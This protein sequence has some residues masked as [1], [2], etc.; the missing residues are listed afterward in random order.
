MNIVQNQDISFEGIYY[1][2]LCQDGVWRYITIDDHLPVRYDGK[3]HLLF[4]HIVSESEEYEVW[5]GLIEKA[6]A[7][8]YG[9]YE[10]L[11]AR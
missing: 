11:R 3:V 5:P 8:V 7:K 4:E 9:T 1:L 6:L 10:D 2:H